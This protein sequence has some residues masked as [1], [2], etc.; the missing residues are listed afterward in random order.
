MADWQGPIFIVGMPRSGTKLL[1]SL[2]NN[3]S[4][5]ALPEYETE[6]LPYWAQHWHEYGDLTDF[7]RFEAFY[8]AARRLAFFSYW[9]EQQGG[10]VTA[11][12]WYQACRD[13]S[14][15]AVFEALVRLAANA[16]EDTI[17]GDKSPSYIR[18]IPLLQAIYPTA[19]IIHI[20]RIS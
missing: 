4:R 16:T 2:L 18:H 14:V 10:C 20:V 8:R 7:V 1:R 12:Q 9:Q 15:A 5:I 6:I 13:G 19:K 3:H 17:W 11:E